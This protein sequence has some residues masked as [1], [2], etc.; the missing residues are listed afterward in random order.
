MYF[1]SI[2]L[3]KKM[4]LKFCSKIAL[5]LLLNSACFSAFSQDNCP[6]KK[7][8]L[9]PSND[10]ER[11]ALTNV[12]FPEITVKSLSSKAVVL[13]KE[14]L[15]KPTFICILMKD[16]GRPVAASWT[17]SILEK[18][19]NQAVNLYE[20]SL[21]PKGLKILRG[22]IEKGMRKSVD[23]SFHNNYTTFFGDVKMYKT[24][25]KIKDDNSSYVYLLDKSGAIQG[26]ADGY[27]DVTKLANL[28]AKVVEINAQN[29]EI[30]LTQKDTITYIFDPLCGF[31]YAFE[32]E[33][34][35]LQAKYKDKFV[36]E[37]ISGGMILGTEEGP[38]GKVAPHISYGYKDLEKMSDARFGSVFLNKIM[39]EG[40][41]KMSSEMPSIAVEVFKS[42]QPD[43]AIAFAS[44]VQTMLYFDGVS[45]NEAEN[46]AVLATKYGL[47]AA[48]FVAKLKQPEWKTK[49]YA[50]FDAAQ[51]LGVQSFPTLILKQNGKTQAINAGFA[52]FEK[53]IKI[54]PFK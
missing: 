3:I 42:L 54:F 30:P 51:K 19:P 5:I 40:T 43:S 18:Y 38:I 21:L 20:V 50:Q 16:E 4:R 24:T 41:Y 7:V 15:G 1:H 48:E 11:A 27:S 29:V 45:L 9:L 33:M 36:F 22:T 35:K 34:K 37:I 31:C 46:Y 12:K 44:D 25:L 13:P 8:N 17:K 32:P 39:K 47:N 28:T 14:T 10:V 49:T 2:K 23:S 26:S 6:V 53:L 52:R